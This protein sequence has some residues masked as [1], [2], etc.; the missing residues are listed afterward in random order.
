MTNKNDGVKRSRL[1]Y[2][3]EGTTP[4]YI[5]E[6]EADSYLIRGQLTAESFGKAMNMQLQEAEVLDTLT[7]SEVEEYSNR[8]VL[9]YRD[10]EWEKADVRLDIPV[11]DDQIDARIHEYRGPGERVVEETVEDEEV[12]RMAEE[13]FRNF[14]GEL[15]D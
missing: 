13:A 10:D 8:Q 14:R 15:F 7:E 4:A 2:G 6:T 5:M 1:N 11:A 3:L 12:E 9:E